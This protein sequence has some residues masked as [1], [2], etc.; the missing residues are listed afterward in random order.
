MCNDEAWN[1][2]ICS[3][4]ANIHVYVHVDLHEI[5]LLNVNNELPSH[6]AVKNPFSAKLYFRGLCITGKKIFNFLDRSRLLAGTVYCNLYM[7]I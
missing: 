1:V 4:N 2:V 5:Y 7:C 3:I 6:T